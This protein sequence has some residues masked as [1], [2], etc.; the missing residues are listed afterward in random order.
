M[1]PRHV[2][3]ALALLF[4][5]APLGLRA[6]GVTARPFE[7]RPMAPKPSPH[8]GWD[9]FDQTT[10]FFTDRMPLR[11]QAV[12][13]QTWAARNVLDVPPRW[14]RDLLSGQAN[15][16][17]LPQDKQ[18]A[19]VKVVEDPAAASGSRVVEGKHG[20]LF[21]EDDLQRACSP[22]LGWPLLVERL[23]RLA[24]G[25]RSSGR[26]VVV[27]IAPDKSTVYPELVGERGRQRY[28]CAEANRRAYWPLMERSAEPALLPLR[29]ALLDA[30]GA[31]EL[32]RSTDS[33]WNTLGGS[34]AVRA[35]L[36]RLD[37]GVRVAP[38]EI[39][40]RPPLK[41][42][43][44]L[45]TLLGIAETSTTPDRAVV[46]R[47]GAPKLGG[48]TLFISDSYGLHNAPLLV[49]YAEKL[50]Q[51][52]WPIATPDAMIAAVE[53]ADHVIIQIIEREVPLQFLDTSRF[54]LLLRAVEAG[55]KPRSA[56]G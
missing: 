47:P 39:V 34:V 24:R 51:M 43:G 2:I 3:T 38:G 55:L 5:L 50:T 48:E 19:P 18:L 10:R 4:F 28:P 35:I 29:Q 54:A 20:W 15:T 25:I 14:R 27:A 42:T 41:Y 30:K 26:D 16:A 53:R 21:L 1:Q 13:A 11:E 36:D 45:N 7:N 46:R 33:H 23:E 6:V 9:V 32:Y 49:P 37:A 44:D 52:Q 17:A 8:A 56:P 31:D 40:T 12:R 22:A